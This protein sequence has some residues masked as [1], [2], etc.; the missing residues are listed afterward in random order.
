MK[1]SWKEA[2]RNPRKVEEEVSIRESQRME[3][4]FGKYNFSWMVKKFIYPVSTM[5]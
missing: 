1:L 2:I 4:T 5:K 3:L